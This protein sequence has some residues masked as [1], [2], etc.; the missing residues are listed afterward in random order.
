MAAMLVIMA[1]GAIGGAASSGYNSYQQQDKIN[2]NICSAK[3]TMAAYIQTSSIEY[4][5]YTA[6]YNTQKKKLKSLNDQISALNED[7]KIAHDSFKKNYTFF[8]IG[9]I[10]VLV[11]LVFIFVSK[12]LILHE[13]AM[14]N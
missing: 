7:T 2:K 11:I 12:K 8:L 9:G 1:L 6:E 13:T 14:K 5:E 3:S 4:E 10:S